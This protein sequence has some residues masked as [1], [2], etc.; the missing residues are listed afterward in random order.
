MLLEHSTPSFAGPKLQANKPLHAQLDKLLALKQDA[1]NT[2]VTISDQFEA[3][4]LLWVA[5]PEYSNAITLVL[6]SKDI[7]NITSKQIIDTLLQEESLRATSAVAGC[8]SNTTN[9]P[10][11]RGLCGKKGHLQE[12]CWDDPKNAHKRKGKGKP[13]ND[14][15][16]RPRYYPNT[17]HN[18]SRLCCSHRSR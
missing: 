4:A 7:A 11:K 15:T 12:N 8:V 2:G 5:P 6:Q 17:Q 10:K 3:F 9:K 1:V 16:L 18:P 14:D 13:S